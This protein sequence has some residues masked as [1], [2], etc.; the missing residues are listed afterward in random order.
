MIRFILIVI[1]VVLYTPK[2][3]YLKPVTLEISRKLSVPEYVFDV[4]DG[5]FILADAFGCKNS[6]RFEETANPER[7]VIA[8]SSL[9]TVPMNRTVE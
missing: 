7:A 1:F 4:V 3:K 9:V 2:S 8:E 5:K 6:V